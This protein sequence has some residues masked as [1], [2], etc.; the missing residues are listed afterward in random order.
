MVH[1]KH[2]IAQFINWENFLLVHQL[3]KSLAYFSKFAKK[4]AC[5][6][7]WAKVNFQYL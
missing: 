1:L 6:I 7:N 2:E 5:F 3:C 4:H